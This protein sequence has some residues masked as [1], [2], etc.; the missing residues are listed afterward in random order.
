MQTHQ[1][2]WTTVNNTQIPDTG[3]H[4]IEKWVY[5]NIQFCLLPIVYLKFNGR[6][7]NKTRNQKLE[8]RVEALQAFFNCATCA[9]QSPWRKKKTNDKILWLDFN[10]NPDG[11]LLTV[12]KLIDTIWIYSHKHTI[13][14]QYE[15]KI[16]RA[17]KSC[18]S[19]I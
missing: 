6:T 19:F 15:N 3:R 17:H 16:P 2:N 18:Q 13:Y 8:L 12:F 7:K 11:K 1:K 14:W 9:S 5:W 4:H 10:R